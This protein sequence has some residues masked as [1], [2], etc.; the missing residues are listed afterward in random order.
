MWSMY[1]VHLYAEA[2]PE[3]LQADLSARI[4][5]PRAGYESLECTLACMHAPSKLMLVLHPHVRHGS[6]QLGLQKFA[7]Q[8]IMA[9][10][11]MSSCPACMAKLT[12]L[13][14]QSTKYIVYSSCKQ[15]HSPPNHCRWSIGAWFNMVE[16]HD[17][18]LT[19]DQAQSLCNLCAPWQHG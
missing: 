19:Q 12:W 13:G 10:R 9:T 16:D 5:V 1:V 8:P 7:L 2:F 17:M 11:P 6:F 3:W 4:K 18:Y 15:S 14:L